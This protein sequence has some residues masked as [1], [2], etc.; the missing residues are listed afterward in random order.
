[1]WNIISKDLRLFILDRKALVLSL[2]LPIALISLFV[3]AYGGV[4]DKNTKT[5][6]KRI[7]LADEDSTT[8]SR[9]IVKSLDSIPGIA[10]EEV[11]LEQGKAHV[12]KGDRIAVLVFYAGFEDSIN[13][14][15]N[16]PM[17]LLYDESR[18]NEVGL[19][20]QAL[21]GNLMETIG[22]QSVEKNI[23]KKVLDKYG[24]LS[25]D[26]LTDIESDISSSFS[27]D[28]GV[29]PS[30][31]LT[32]TSIKVEERIN[33]ALIQAVAGTIIMML[34]FT[35]MGTSGTILEEMEEGT[36][37][38]LF[39]SPTRPATIFF[40][41]YITA[42][43]VGFI[44]M[45]I[46]LLFA[47]IAFGL[48]LFANFVPLLFTVI[49]TAFAC[50]SFGSFLAS[51]SKTRK[52]LESFGMIVILVM[53]AIG[54]SMIPLFIMPPI[55]RKIAVISVNYWSIESFY[56]VFGRLLTLQ[57]ILPNLAVLFGMGIVM[58]LISHQLYRR[59]IVRMFGK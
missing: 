11:S 28:S 5:P 41:K 10:W 57:D 53:S 19:L 59:N 30:Y 13:N 46:L 45:T 37:K 9:N 15:K 26:I 55:M 35:M 3:F 52:Q 29:S 22:R 14:G 2:L 54:G 1:M 58:L 48:D 47:W 4:N 25:S 17:E 21:I 51:I 40:A 12:L 43:I 44:Q 56:D 31:N 32:V 39:L 27:D 23:K 7:L 49:A 33:W 16:Y 36:L 24:Y 38:R 6:P 34:L 42:F 50:S 20:Q 8:T 18:E